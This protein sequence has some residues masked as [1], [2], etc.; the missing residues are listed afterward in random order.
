MLQIFKEYEWIG[1]GTEHPDHPRAG[2]RWI[3]IVLPSASL[4]CSDT[5]HKHGLFGEYKICSVLSVQNS[6]ESKLI[7]YIL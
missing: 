3:S 4:E 2:S 7:I 5:K 1:S 6:V